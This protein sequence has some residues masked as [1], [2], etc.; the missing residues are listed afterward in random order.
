MN[1]EA[2]YSA[3]YDQLKD[4]VPSAKTV[5]RFLSHWADVQ[6]AD[7]PYVGIAQQNQAT[8]AQIALPRTWTLHAHLWCYVMGE[9]SEKVELLPAYML[10]T[11][12]DEIEA[13]LEPTFAGAMSRQT[14]GQSFIYDAKIDGVINTDEGWLGK[15]AVAIVPVRIIVT[16]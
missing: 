13:A 5:T 14:L 3:L 10:N 1:R 6:P 9:Q 8:K 15:V 11:L 2:A 12:L 4:N 7:M 16:Q